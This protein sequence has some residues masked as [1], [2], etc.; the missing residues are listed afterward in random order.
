MTEL[1]SRLREALSDQYAIE[2]QLG[3]GGMATV[4]LGRD[5]RH[6]RDVALKVLNPELAVVVGAERFSR[7]IDIAARLSH[8]HILP[9][10]NS[11]SFRLH[12]EVPGSEIPYYVMPFV[13]G[14]SL[15]DRLA[16]D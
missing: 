11:G 13:E 14:E 12:A 4:F 15:R 5:L 6:R 16:R 7:E 8:P 1:L 3:Q 9:L 2:R 10:L